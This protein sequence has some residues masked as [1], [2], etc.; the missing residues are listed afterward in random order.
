VHLYS[1]R[2]KQSP[3]P[4]KLEKRIIILRRKVIVIIPKGEK[5]IHRDVGGIVSARLGESKEC[6]ECS[7][8]AFALQIW[9][10]SSIILLFLLGCESGKWRDLNPR[11]S[12]VISI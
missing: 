6:S 10:P 8:K 4:R 9:A 12:I 2:R 3:V 7:V 11:G 1:L 5:G